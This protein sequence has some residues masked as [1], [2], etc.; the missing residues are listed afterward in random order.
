[1]AV[2]TDSLILIQLARP[3][4]TNPAVEPT[5][6]INHY[7]TNRYTIN[8]E[9]WLQGAA[10]THLHILLDSINNYNTQNS[11]NIQLS[12]RGAYMQLKQS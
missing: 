8:V 1:V 2:Q 10:K 4:T 3:G 9:I 11:D 12:Y 7:A 6:A 5:I